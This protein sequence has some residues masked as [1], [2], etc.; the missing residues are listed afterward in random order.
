MRLFPANTEPVRTANRILCRRHLGL[1]RFKQIQGYQTSVD[2]VVFVRGYRV[3]FRT[4]KQFFAARTVY[5]D[6]H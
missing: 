5:R 6:C 4:Q 3:E 1:V 2:D